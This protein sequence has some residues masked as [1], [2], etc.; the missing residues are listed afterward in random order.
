M[1]LISVVRS[2][3]DGALASTVRTVLMTLRIRFL[4]L[5]VMA[6]ETQL[7]LIR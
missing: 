3:S 1:L 5:L 4:I 6:R 2:S 7:P